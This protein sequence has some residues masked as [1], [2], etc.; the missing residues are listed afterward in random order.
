MNANQIIT[1]S[2]A[3]LVAIINSGTVVRAATGNPPPPTPTEYQFTTF[4]EP[5]AVFLA[6]VGLNNQ[7]TSCGF[8]ETPLGHGF[9]W[10]N[11]SLV[12][13]DAPG[14]TET[15]PTGINDVGVVTGSYDDLVTSHEF[16]YRVKD[17]KWTQLP[18]IAGLPFLSNSAINNQGTVVGSYYFAGEGNVGWIWDGKS[19]SFFTAP[20]AYEESGDGTNPL[21]IND[22]GQITG[23]YADDE[24]FTHGF[25]KE[26]STF[27][28]FDVP[29]ADFT[30]AFSINNQGDIVGTY[31]IIG[32]P[33]YPEQGFI[34]H[35]GVFYTFP[36][37]GYGG[38][39][40]IND[41]GEVAG[42]YWDPA[43]DNDWHGFVAK[44]KH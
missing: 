36:L 8:Y 7:G 17:G 3:T 43:V 12:N 18:D 6:P 28:T 20:G 40:T 27:T 41:R 34:L 19:Y 14:W 33:Y 10:S 4:D 23:F 38:L 1:L 37:P 29:G 30:E 35:G 25:L 44:P 2:V 15:W 42:T 32:T 16:L 26:G 31:Y 39:T 13:L 11:G 22:R 5:G 24:G 21:G 9:L